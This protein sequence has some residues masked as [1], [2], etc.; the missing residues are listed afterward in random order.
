MRDIQK[1]PLAMPIMTTPGI[2]ETMLTNNTFLEQVKRCME[3]YIEVKRVIFP[4]F[5]FLSNDELLE[6]LAQTKNPHAV[7]P[8]LKKCFDMVKLEFG[9]KPAEKKGEKEDTNDIVAMISEEGERVQFGRGL[10]ARG[11]VEDWLSK[12]EDAMHTALKRCMKF[13]LLK[14][15]TTPRRT[16]FQEHPSQISLTVSQ[17]QWALAVHAILDEPSGTLQ[18][19]KMKELEQKSQRDL[20]ELASVARSEI[21]F[22]VR[23]I[24]G[25]LITVDVHAKDTITHMIKMGV[26]KT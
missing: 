8:H 3:A 22:L 17:Q 10:K 23:K 16:W 26:S 14:Y 6:I 19:S 25:A 2:Y 4:R 11:S 12:V 15:S 21:P 9:T 18:K 1:Y 24:L 7:Q 5:Y 20:A 13:A